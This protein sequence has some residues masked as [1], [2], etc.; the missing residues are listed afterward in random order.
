MRK[1]KVLRRVDKSYLLIYYKLLTTLRH[2]LSC[3]CYVTTPP[4]L[5]RH[6]TKSAHWLSGRRG[7]GIIFVSPQHT[8]YHTRQAIVGAVVVLLLFTTVY[9]VIRF[10]VRTYVRTNDRYVWYIRKSL[11][12]I[13]NY[14]I[15]C[16]ET[17]W[18]RFLYLLFLLLCVCVC[19]SLF[20]FVIIYGDRSMLERWRACLSTTSRRC[21]RSM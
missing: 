10:G 1:V 7:K 5:P 3:A 12:Y 15:F 14:C 13:W 4:P 16:F 2:P 11:V 18:L 19:V 17:F 9:T 8:T 6:P 20:V 21:V